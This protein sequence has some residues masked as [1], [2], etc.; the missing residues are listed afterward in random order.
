MVSTLSLIFCY[1]ADVCLLSVTLCF[2]YLYIEHTWYVMLYGVAMRTVPV[3]I[4][5]RLCVRPSRTHS[6]IWSFCLCVRPSAPALPYTVPSQSCRLVLCIRPSSSIKL[7][8]NYWCVLN[9]LDPRPTGEQWIKTNTLSGS[10]IWVVKFLS[11]ITL[12]NYS[13]SP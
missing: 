5:T 3:R 7:A 4:A 9:K 10:W 12:Y 13:N 1:I 8:M 2:W 11:G 6:Q